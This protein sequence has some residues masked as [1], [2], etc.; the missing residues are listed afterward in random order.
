MA[1]ITR[2]AITDQTA[3]STTTFQGPTHA[4]SRMVAETVITA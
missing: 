3:D 1:D 2:M 4:I